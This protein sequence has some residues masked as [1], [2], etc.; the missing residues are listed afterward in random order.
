MILYLDTSVLVAALTREAET[1][2]MQTWLGAQ[3]AENLA[4]S[5][6]VITEFS[7]ALSIK[8]RGGQIDAAQRA[9]AFG[10]FARLSQESFM[11][12]P[13]SGAQFRTATR[14]ADQHGLGLRAGDALH[15]AICGECGATLCTL[16]RGLSTAGIE[17]GVK[18]ALL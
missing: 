11:I 15:L 4:I 12:L 5:D 9:D 2:R 18:T 3:D 7:S 17:V 13:V 6:W 16:D 10:L 14:F 1:G 8:L